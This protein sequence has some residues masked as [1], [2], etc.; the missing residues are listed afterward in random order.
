MA[1]VPNMF[2]FYSKK[3]FDIFYISLI[4]FSLLTNK[5]WYS[6]SPR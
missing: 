6:L 3:G 4:V 5:P 2:N 1:F